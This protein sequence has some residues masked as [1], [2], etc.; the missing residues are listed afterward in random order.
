MKKKLLVGILGIALLV[1]VLSG[2]VEDTD[3]PEPEPTNNA[4]TVAFD[5]DPV[6]THNESLAGGTVTFAI[7]ATDEDEDDT[8]TYAWA[9]GDDETSTEEDPEHIYAENGSYDVTVTVSD[10]TD[11]ATATVTVVV[12]N[13]APTAAFTYVADN[14]TVNFTDASTDDGEISAWLWDF[15]DDTTST[16]E[17]PDVTYATNGT[18]TVT[19]TVTDEFGLESTEYTEDITVEETVAE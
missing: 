11:T 9:F 1:G 6:V 19:L 4:P 10:G 16:E 13:Q 17:N 8:H 2:C 12:G 14:L 3:E 15:G 5:S 18:Y 7:T